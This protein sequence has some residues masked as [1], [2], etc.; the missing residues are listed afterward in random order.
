MPKRKNKSGSNRKPICIRV[1]PETAV[2]L[3]GVAV[4]TGTSQGK[5]I[6]TLVEKMG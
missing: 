6:D 2:K 5:V 3:A 4:E 1:K